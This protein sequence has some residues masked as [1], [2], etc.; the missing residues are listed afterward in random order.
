[1]ISQVIINSSVNTKMHAMLRGTLKPGDYDK[2]VNMK[3]VPEAAEFLKR[4]PRFEKAFDNVDIENIHRGQLEARLKVLMTRDLKAFMAFTGTAA[5][6]FLSLFA[7]KNETVYLKLLL[8]LQTSGNRESLS[9]A[10]RFE[11][12]SFSGIDFT[13]LANAASFDDFVHALENTVYERA[14]RSFVG[15]PERQNT[16]EL[17]MALDIFYRNLVYRYIA[18]YLTGAERE[19]VEK[20]FGAETDIE[21]IMFIMRSKMYYKFKPDMIYPYVKAKNYKLSYDEITEMVE[22]QSDDALMSAIRRTGYGKIFEGSLAHVESRTGLYLLKLHKTMFHRNPYSV[23]AILYYIKFKETEIKNIIMTIEG[24]RYGLEPEEIK[25]Y[26]IGMP[27][28][29]E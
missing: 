9:E 17:E 10:Y 20:T 21:N 25:S 12:E 28:S 27:D 6:S 29:R 13:A 24:I 18:K 3:S 5:K 15:S 2:M 14:L 11:D 26:L 23:E 8:R 1:M 19:S 16:F 4:N 22:A 7:I